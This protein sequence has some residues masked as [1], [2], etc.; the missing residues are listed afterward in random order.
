[1]VQNHSHRTTNPRCDCGMVDK[2]RRSKE[3]FAGILWC[4]GCMSSALASLAPRIGVRVVVVRLVIAKEKK[5]NQ[6][7]HAPPPPHT[8]IHDA[9]SRISVRTDPRAL[10]GSGVVFFILTCLLFLLRG[11]KHDKMYAEKGEIAAQNSAKLRG[12]TCAQCSIP[13]ILQLIQELLSPVVPFRASE[14]QRVLL[15]ANQSQPMLDD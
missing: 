9:R 10:I 4:I 3:P 1:M 2:T 5:K 7:T 11:S 12:A 8:H 15:V 13:S 14:R 6:S